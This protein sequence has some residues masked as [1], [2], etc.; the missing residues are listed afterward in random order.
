MVTSALTLCN[1][2][3]QVKVIDFLLP[4]KIGWPK[5]YLWSHKKIFARFFLWCTVRR[6]KQ[7]RQALEVDETQA[8]SHGIVA[9]ADRFTRKSSLL[10]TGV[11][12]KKPGILF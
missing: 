3:G 1:R 9:I 6:V 10:R 12:W 4:I 11:Q 5:I 2:S 8:L 7:G